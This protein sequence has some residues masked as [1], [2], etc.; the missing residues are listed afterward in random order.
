[1][2]LGTLGEKG[3][4]T[5]WVILYKGGFLS[6]KAKEE[7][8]G[9][10]LLLFLASVFWGVIIKCPKQPML[11]CIGDIFGIRWKIC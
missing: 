7:K 1:M 3:N 2:E 4:D 5:F 6:V 10:F 8:N 9:L 11:Y